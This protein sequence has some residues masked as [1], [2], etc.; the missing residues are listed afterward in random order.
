MLYLKYQIITLFQSK[1]I[2]PL[3]NKKYL[4]KPIPHLS[5]LSSSI[6][7]LYMIKDD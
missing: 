6:L 4:Y 2:K 7:V 1:K 3:A 5:Q